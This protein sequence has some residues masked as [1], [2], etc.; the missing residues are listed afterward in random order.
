MFYKVKVKDFIRV[1]PSMF[2]LPR[3]EAVLK[4]V[5]SSYEG[6]IS[7][8]FGF[9]LNVIDVGEVKEG[10]IVPGDGAAY[11]DTNFE[12]L[13]FKPEMNEIVYG[14][15]R[16][17]ID[18][19]AFMDL[20]GIEG[21][22]HISQSMDDFVSFSKDKVL[23]GKKS[24]Q[25]LKVGDRCKARIIAARFKDMNNPKIGL[26]MRQ[27]GLGKLEWLEKQ[28]EVPAGSKKEE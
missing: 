6:F 5:R 22:V 19:G 27:E 11:Y 7:K 21:M 28:N 15:I 4:N 18:F 3:K 23:Q 13:A 17:I 10:V 9:V 25:S 2:D 16:D 8:D 12:L 1:P 14:K 24:G 20:G 26:T